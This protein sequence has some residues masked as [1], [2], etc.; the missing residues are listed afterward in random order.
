MNTVT[1]SRSANRSAALLAA[2]GFAGIALF[3]VALAAGVP[4]GHAAWGGSHAHRSSPERIGSA[5]AAPSGRRR[6]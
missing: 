3:Q 2:I 4:W 1:R 6:P 5:V